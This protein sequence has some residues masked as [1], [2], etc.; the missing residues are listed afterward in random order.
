[1]QVIKRVESTC[2]QNKIKKTSPR[3]NREWRTKGPKPGSADSN[4]SFETYIDQ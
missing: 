1:M 2:R 3:L 4:H